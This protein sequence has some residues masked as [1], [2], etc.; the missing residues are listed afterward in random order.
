LR[1]NKEDEIRGL[2]VL[3]ILAI[4]ISLKT[5]NVTLNLDIFGN[6]L[7]LSFIINLLLLFWF[8]Y[9]IIVLLA[10]SNL[11]DEKKS[12]I[13]ME[14]SSNIISL[15]F[16]FVFTFLFISYAQFQPI[17][18][19]VLFIILIFYIEFNYLFN[20]IIS[21][22]KNKIKITK[23]DIIKS[24]IN[25][26]NAKLINLFAI[27][28]VIIQILEINEKIENNLVLLFLIL[29]IFLAIYFGL[30]HQKRWKN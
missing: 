3:G 9:A 26:K 7:D 30:T 21:F 6:N 28:I 11:F 18:S 12:K 24:F 14:N 4:L 19:F 17:K 15:G 22:R 27:A 13:I 29:I 20:L 10:L 25:V 23:K 5:S 16:M 8:L 1:I 2:Y